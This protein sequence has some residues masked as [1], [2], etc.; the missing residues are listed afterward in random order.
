MSDYKVGHGKPPKEYQIGQPLGPKP[1][2]TKETRAKQIAN[3]TKVTEIRERMLNAILAKM[4]SDPD[5]IDTVLSMIDAHV[6]KMM[7]DTENRGLGMPTQQ[8]DSTSSDGTMSPPAKIVVKGV[9][10]KESE[11]DS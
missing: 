5:D 8:I 4:D 11:D 6:N 7:A 10:P 3:A 1:G 9:K 2:I